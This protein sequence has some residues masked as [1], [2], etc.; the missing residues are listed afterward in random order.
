MIENISLDDG[1]IKDGCSAT[2]SFA[3]FFVGSYMSLYKL[4]NVALHV[5]AGREGSQATCYCCSA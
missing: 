2:F 4:V 5:F 1:D 3:C